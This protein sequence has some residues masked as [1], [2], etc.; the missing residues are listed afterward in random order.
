MSLST[1]C[2]TEDDSEKQRAAGTVW[3]RA[4]LTQENPSVTEH[5]SRHGH[6]GPG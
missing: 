3:R 2:G 5:V 6:R 4:A 1:S